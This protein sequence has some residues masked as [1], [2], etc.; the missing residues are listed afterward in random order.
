MGRQVRYTDT[1]AADRLKM[2]K[3]LV[4]GASG[5]IGDYVVSGLLD[6]G[7]E[8]IASSAD[9]EKIRNREWY[10]RV[11]YLPLDFG[12][13]DEATNYF[14]YFRKPELVIHL[15]W[16]GLPNYQALFHFETNLPRHY[17]FIKNLVAHGCNDLTVTGTC[18]EYGMKEG[19]LSESMPADPANP[20]AIAKFALYKFLDALR[21]KTPFA[22]K[23]IRLFYMYGKGQNPNSL[24]SQLE[25]ALENGDPV[26][27]MSGGEQ[28]RDFLQIETVA[29]Y[30]AAIA[31]QKK[32]TGIIN[33]CSGRPRT[34][35]EL[36]DEIVSQSGRSIR[37][38]RGFYPY[39]TYEPMH[40][41][42]D[43]SKL[44]RI[45]NNE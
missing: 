40:F 37:L 7:H 43:D 9:P 1:F 12:S 3:I 30:I 24:F 29:Q 34:V 28:Q 33:C 2:K 44:N 45:L 39:N 36:V 20:Y 18:F 42:G 27:N 22:F 31:L 17:M 11:T 16:E 19:M 15:A 13:I 38:N 26:F 10:R 21:M 35:N 5:F 4:T 6:A 41:W 8:V 32:E 25:R 14:E 23:W